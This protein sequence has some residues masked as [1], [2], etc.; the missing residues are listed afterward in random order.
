[1]LRDWHFG[2]L[3]GWLQSAA[4]QVRGFAPEKLGSFL[5]HGVCD[6]FS[7]NLGGDRWWPGGDGD[8]RLR[9]ADIA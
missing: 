9:A 2:G 5:S 7:E 4:L 6:K 1:M 3:H 8:S